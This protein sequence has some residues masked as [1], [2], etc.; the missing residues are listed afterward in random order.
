M[1]I[2][3]AIEIRDFVVS[4]E[5]NGMN[6]GAYIAT[7]MG[8]GKILQKLASLTLPILEKFFMKDTQIGIVCSMKY[9]E[10]SEFLKC[11]GEE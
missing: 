1:N 2:N 4:L 7:R 8:Y 6:F 3:E 5:N 11:I 10:Y 9:F